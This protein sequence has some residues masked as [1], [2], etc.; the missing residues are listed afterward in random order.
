MCSPDS[1]SDPF[2]GQVVEQLSSTSGGVV[3]VVCIPESSPPLVQESQLSFVPEPPGHTFGYSPE[4]PPVD[5][6]PPV[7]YVVDPPEAPPDD[8]LQLPFVPELSGYTFGYFP[9]EL[10]S[11]LL[12]EELPPVVGAVGRQLVL[13]TLLLGYTVDAVPVVVLIFCHHSGKVLVSIILG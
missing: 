2:P 7:G 10:L 5:V 4:E 9:G 6:P 12:F 1:Q 13:L 11:I 8:V 3:G